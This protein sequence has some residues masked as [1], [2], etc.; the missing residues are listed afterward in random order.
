MSRIFVKFLCMIDDLLF[1][2]DS[3]DIVKRNNKVSIVGNC[4]ILARPTRSQL[5]LTQIIGRGTRLSPIGGLRKAGGKGWTPLGYLFVISGFLILAYYSVIAGWATRYALET[6]IFGVPADAG[7]HFEAI[8]T[9]ITA[10]GFHLFFMAIVI[11]IVMGGIEKGIERAALVMM[12]L[13]FLL[14]LGLAIWAATLQGSGAGYAFYLAPSLG[15]LFNVQTI[16]D[17]TGQA[18]FS[19]SLGMGAMLTFSSYLSKEES[20]PREATVI[21][22]SDFAVA[23]LAGLVVFPVIAAL[24][25]QAAVDES[26]VGALFIALPGAFEAMGSIG[27]LVASVFFIALFIAAVT[28]A[29]SLLEVVTASII[30]EWRLPRKAAAIG[31]GILIAIVG[32]WPAVNLDA[33][34]AMDEVAANVFL[35]LG[36]F[37]MAIL[38]GWQLKDPI[39]EVAKNVSPG[40]RP[41]LV[42]WVWLLRV[43]VPILLILVLYD[44]VPTAIQAVRALFAG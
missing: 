9:G 10:I 25:L 24:G 43:V 31:A 29:I 30:D 7:G 36:A 17:A 42:A 15:D 3:P 33:L 26:T 4:I 21:S 44:K 13:L 16:S 18:F 12:P 5:L 41:W 1:F 8:S 37:F 40:V 27:R 11:G 35:P 32:L 19:L 22:F 28:S 2:D 38:V 39:G 20:L 23:F 6:T 34:G 14:I